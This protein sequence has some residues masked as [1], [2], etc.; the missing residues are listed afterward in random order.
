MSPDLES[1]VDRDLDRFA[2][3]R[4]FYG[5]A[6]LLALEPVLVEARRLPQPARLLLCHD[7]DMTP[8]LEAFFGDRIHLD[9]LRQEQQGEVVTRQVTLRLTSSDRAVEFGAIRIN[10]SGLAEPQEQFVREGRQPLGAILNAFDIPHESRASQ[11]FRIK[12][13]ALMV[14]CFALGGPQTLYGRCNTLRYQG[15]ATLADVVEVLPP[16]SLS[17][18][19][20]ATGSVP[21]TL[22][23]QG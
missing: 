19:S 11:F 14:K 12:A 4:A 15:G 21:G 9:V 7:S 18:R 13:D 3:L 5:T 8:M 23:A 17:E 1:L 16:L 22:P 6:G 2:P 10:L 20:G